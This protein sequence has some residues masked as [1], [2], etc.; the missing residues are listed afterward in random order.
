[1][2]G[3][4][5]LNWKAELFRVPNAAD[6]SSISAPPKTLRIT[7]EPFYRSLESISW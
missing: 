6:V 7:T 2:T 4:L 3:R 5:K 1:L